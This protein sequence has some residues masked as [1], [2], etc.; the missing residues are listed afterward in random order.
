MKMRKILALSLSAMMLGSMGMAVGCGPERAGVSNDAGTINVAWQVAGY[1]E[2]Y[3]REVA[4]AFNKLYK[5]QGYKVNLLDPDSTLEGRTALAEMRLGMAS[6]VDLYMPGTVRIWDVLDEE[7]GICVEDL[8]D[9]YNSTYINFDGTE[10]TEPFKNSIK[11]ANGKTY[12]TDLA[13]ENYYTFGHVTSTR[14]IVC[15]AKLLNKYGITEMPRTT[16]ELFDAYDAIYYGANGR[17]STAETGIYPTTWGGSNAF[18]Y[19][20]NSS[21]THLAQMLGS[22]AY[23]AFYKMDNLIQDG[24]V[25]ADSWKMYENEAIKDVLEV[26]IQQYDTAY[27][28]RG[29]VGQDHHKAHSQIITGKAAFMTD[30]EFFFNEV[31]ANF[32]QYLNDVTFV[33]IPVMSKLGVNLKLDG[34]GL[35]REK[36]DDILSAIIKGVDDGKDNATIKSE[37]DA[38]FSVSLNVETQ[39]ERIRDARGCAFSSGIGS[40]YYVTK[41]TQKKA[42]CEL[43]LRM[44]GSPDSAKV[45]AKY[46]MLS[47]YSFMD[48]SEYQYQFTKDAAKI[49]KNFTYGVTGTPYNGTLRQA[50]NLFLYPVYSAMMPVTI[51]TEIGVVENPSARDYAALAQTA[52]EKNLNDVQK[53]WKTYMERA[54]YVL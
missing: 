47:A 27:S 13:G 14:G 17:G 25:S 2:G 48:E 15:N 8:N 28:V 12:L 3:I 7:F 1:G 20:M 49:I 34:T 54:G 46:G 43:F 32:G 16:D 53:N 18:G 44:L 19:A 5:E 21:Y 11:H 37:V 10:G 39:V 38:Q 22:E 30:G 26:F 40:G 31:R 33:N 42:I 29:A 52:Y 50:T 36:C 35:D 41:G 45:L 6:G 4:E 23:D 9:L 51:A 24:Q